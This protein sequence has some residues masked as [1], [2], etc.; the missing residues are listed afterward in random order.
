MGTVFPLTPTPT[1]HTDHTGGTVPIRTR[2]AA[3]PSPSQVR[4]LPFPP[5]GDPAVETTIGELTA[6]CLR[7]PRSFALLRAPLLVCGAQVP[8]RQRTRCPR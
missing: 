5:T 2:R 7:A 3:S 6:D 1:R 8:S 4:T